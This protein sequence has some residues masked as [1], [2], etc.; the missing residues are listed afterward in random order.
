MNSPGAATG[1]LSQDAVEPESRRVGTRRA[2]GDC[3]RAEQLR[4]VNE[5]LFGTPTP[6]RLDPLWAQD[7]VGAGLL[8]DFTLAAD[9]LA[10]PVT[11]NNTSEDVPPKSFRDLY[12][13]ATWPASNGDDDSRKANSHALAT[14]ALVLGHW[15]SSIL[16]DG[17]LDFRADDGPGD[18]STNQSGGVPPADDTHASPLTLYFGSAGNDWTVVEDS[19]AIENSLSVGST[20]ALGFCSDFTTKCT[21]GDVVAACSDNGLI[22][23]DD[24]PFGGTSGASPIA[25]GVA[26]TVHKVH[27]DLSVLALK[28]LL[29]M[30]AD[31]PRTD[32]PNGDRLGH[33]TVNLQKAVA[34]ARHLRNSGAN[35]DTLSA[36]TVK[37]ILHEHMTR[38]TYAQAATKLS[39]PADYAAAVRELYRNALLEPPGETR[40]KGELAKFY[41]AHGIVLSA[42]RW[43]G[44]APSDPALCKELQAIIKDPTSARH[45]KTLALRALHLGGKLGQQEL[46]AIALDPCADP[47]IAGTAA[48]MIA[49]D[50]KPSEQ[51]CARMDELRA[52][53]SN[54]RNDQEMMVAAFFGSALGEPLLSYLPDH[55][56]EQ[57]RAWMA[58][59]ASTSR[60]V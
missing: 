7:F 25:A 52:K 43:L 15:P 4:A 60:P 26:A 18:I 40:A 1:A 13:G 6:G 8:R 30:T 19:P 16:R 17:R 12:P 57:F 10:R 9:E 46:E 41:L 50:G 59:H 22:A 39:R 48:K 31:P 20:D 29:I 11:I 23:M 45:L 27:P 49:L 38:L 51:V 35:V 53:T 2:L 34:V 32:D 24:M 44:T 55:S 33:G 21:G 14:T 3:P 36:D 47:L 58:A 54:P 56:A 42:H 37:D 28:R 5:R